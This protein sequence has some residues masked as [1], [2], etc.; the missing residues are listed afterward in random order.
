MLLDLFAV[1]CRI[2]PATFGGGY[3]MIPVLEEEIVRKR[4]WL[5]QKE[6]GDLISV[7]GSAPGG[8]GVNAATF[9]GYRLA[10]VPGAIAAVVGIALPTF[11]IA[12]ALG[13]IYTKL[14]D[15]PK[16]QAALLGIR[17]AVLGLIAIAGIKMARNALFDRSTVVLFAA[18]LSLLILTGAH[19]FYLI[20]AGMGAGW[21]IAVGK[22]L[23]GC[24]VRLDKAPRPAPDADIR[25]PEYYI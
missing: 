22:R 7:A 17:G 14:E 9:I 12:A 16:V 2:G 1:F 23:L 6:M 3:A 15:E 18:A 21:A 25:F 13:L 8:V 4:S 20:L 10:G 19:P 11:V 24:K 5:M